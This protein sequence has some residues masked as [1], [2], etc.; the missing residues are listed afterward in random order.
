VKQAA[1]AGQSPG[2]KK[3]QGRCPM[4]VSS[5]SAAAYSF[6]R[7]RPG[8]TMHGIAVRFVQARHRVLALA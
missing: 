5:L 1:G 7:I 8:N 4:R 2:R 3:G 6:M